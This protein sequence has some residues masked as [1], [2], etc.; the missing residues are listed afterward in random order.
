MNANEAE[1]R[2]R[3]LRTAYVSNGNGTPEVLD[4][5]RPWVDFYKVD[6]KSMDDKHYR[7]L[8]GVLQNV[9]DT[10]EGIHA[11]GIWLEVL[12]LVI[13]GFNDSEDE[14]RRAAGFVASVSQDIPWHVTA[15]HPDYKM[16]DRGATPAATLLRAAE[17]GTEEGLRYV[18]AG[19]LPGQTGK[20]ENTRCPECGETVIERIGFRIRHNRLAEGA[21]PPSCRH[22]RKWSGTT[23]LSSPTSS[24]TVMSSSSGPCGNDPSSAIAFMSS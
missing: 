12:T 7:E 8:G 14:L 22:G 19:N 24:A 13:P 6:L 11:R 20:W 4:Y 3:G 2:R 16:T 21:C 23:A 10:I 1:A 9:L 17:I 5:I 18:Y 15:F